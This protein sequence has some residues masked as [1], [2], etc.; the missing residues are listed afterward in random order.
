MQQKITPNLWFN[1]NALEAAE[2][3]TSIF[4][5]GNI[6]GI[7]YYPEGKEDG[8]ADFQQ[9]L[10]GKELTV[11]FEIE[12]Y[13]LVAINGGS[14]FQF[15]PSISFMVNFDPSRDEHA[16]ERLD[17]LWR[18]LISG[19]E[20]LMPLEKYDFSE[21]YGWVKDRYGLTWQL[22][23]TDPD[24]EPRPFIIP[25]LM[26]GGPV[27]NQADQA[28]DYY[29]SVFEDSRRGVSYAYNEPTGSASAD[30]LMFADFTLADQWFV[31]NDSAVEQEFTFNE[32]VSFEVKCEDQDEIDELWQK[33]SAYPEN[34]QCGWVKDKF[35]VSWQI[36]P[37]NMND[38]MRR[39]GA[40][41]KMME[42]KKIIIDEF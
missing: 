16:R 30:A 20:S 38:L 9:D 23:L 10:A 4:S 39:P 27:Q 8:L 22:I 31:A 28:I 41:A 36:V 26:F 11:T 13:Q 40:F 14:E 1:G 15:T 19:G 37:E 32:A 7:A 17:D 5:N 21:Y 24:G 2:Y 6:S 35:G 3:Y 29:V 12:D 33:L 18:K 25:A 42:M 34:E